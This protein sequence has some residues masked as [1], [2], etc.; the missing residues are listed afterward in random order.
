MKLAKKFIARTRYAN[1]RK[2]ETNISIVI[3]IKT[4]KITNPLSGKF[5]GRPKRMKIQVSPFPSI[6]YFLP[7]LLYSIPSTDVMVDPY[8]K[9]S[10]INQ[11][12]KV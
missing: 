11:E 5:E 10:Q 4:L 7:S 1:K 3:E 12:L 6:Y 9:D 2:V 8:I